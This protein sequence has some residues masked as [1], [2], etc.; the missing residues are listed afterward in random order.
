MAVC[1]KF[2]L[3]SPNLPWLPVGRAL[4]N[5]KS[6]Y[7]RTTIIKKRNGATLGFIFLCVV[8]TLGCNLSTDAPQLLCGQS[9]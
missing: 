3:P 2:T 1:P 7:N 8:M 6:N 5:P 4:A 9:A